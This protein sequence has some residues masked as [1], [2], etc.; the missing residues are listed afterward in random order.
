MI[1]KLFRVQDSPSYPITPI[2]LIANE[3]KIIGWVI[4]KHKKKL[5]KKILIG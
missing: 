2:N 5:I 3:K 4:K 1:K